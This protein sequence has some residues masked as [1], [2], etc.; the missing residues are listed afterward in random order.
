MSI[1]ISGGAEENGIVV[2]NSYNKYASKNPI[3]KW[4]MSGFE[5]TLE[6]FV[7]KVS[8]SAIHEIG[9]GEG[10]WVLRWLEKGFSAKGCDFSTH[11]IGLAR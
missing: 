8:P 9:C 1:K 4:I 6:G 7:S 5:N 10:Y 11:V 3:V 2:G